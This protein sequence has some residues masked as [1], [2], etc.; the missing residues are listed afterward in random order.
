MSCHSHPWLP[1][2]STQVLKYETGQFYKVHHDQNSPRS[3]AWGPRMFTVFMYIGDGY[4][5]GLTHFPR[6]NL[7]IPAKKGAAC[8]WT[9]ILDSDPYQRDDRTDHESLPVESGVKYGVNYWI[10]MYPFRSMQNG[11]CDNQAYIQNWY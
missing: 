8:V 1:S 2:A 10:H 9:S 3:S 6:L 5:G 4:E 7:T 11:N